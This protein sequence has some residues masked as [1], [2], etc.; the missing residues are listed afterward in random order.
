MSTNIGTTQ[1]TAGEICTKR[2]AEF[3]GINGSSPST[4]LSWDAYSDFLGKTIDLNT[5]DPACSNNTARK[6][7]SSLCTVDNSNVATMKCSVSAGLGFVKSGDSCKTV[8]CPPGFR[9]KKGVCE[10]EPVLKDYSRD[11][12]AYCQERWYD[13]FTIPNYQLGNNYSNTNILIK[14]K[15]DGQLAEEVT[16]SN[17]VFCY[18]PCPKGQMPLYRKDPVDNDTMGDETN[19]L[20][21]CVNKNEYFISKYA[22]SDDFCPLAAIHAITSTPTSIKQKL[23]DNYTTFWSH[24]AGEPNVDVQRPLTSRATEDAAY[25][26]EKVIPQVVNDVII[27]SQASVHGSG[28]GNEFAARACSALETPSRVEYAYDMCRKLKDMGDDTTFGD[29]YINTGISDKT[30]AIKNIKHACNALFSD[31]RTSTAFDV[32][33]PPDM[34]DSERLIMFTD[35]DDTDVA[36]LNTD[37]YDPKYDKDPVQPRTLGSTIPKAVKLGIFLALLPFIAFAVYLI[38]T[39]AYIGLRLLIWKVWRPAMKWLDTSPSMV[40]VYRLLWNTIYW[41]HMM[42]ISFETTQGLREKSYDYADASDEVYWFSTKVEEATRHHDSLL[43]K[44]KRLRI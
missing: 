13:W 15:V 42:P 44:L 40:N 43:L 35:V 10:V 23:D 27:S 37:P 39:Y 33:S 12:R 30:K 21:K 22:G 2:A 29:T 26:S 11:K 8:G 18:K 6:A 4:P 9:T 1:V 28:G 14:E 34:S 7:S 17:L 41:L 3:L 20:E 25:I 32:Y 16:T 19:R 24:S 5:Y 36:D 31:V 38:F